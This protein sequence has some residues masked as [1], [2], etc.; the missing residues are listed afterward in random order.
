MKQAHK[1]MP[2]P[3]EIFTKTKL[4]QYGFGKD[5]EELCGPASV[6]MLLDMGGDPSSI[7]DVVK[8]MEQH[9][10]FVQGIGTILA[11]VAR[12]FSGSLTYMPLLP[13]WLLVAM[14]KR[15][16]GFAHSIKQSSGS[17]GHIVC[18]SGYRDGLIYFYDPN[19]NTDAPR[20]VSIGEW[21][22]LSNRRAVAMRT[23]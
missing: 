12:C 3:R 8:A 21:R 15:G 1:M 16:F 2:I 23:A 20:K 10:A 18:V 13:V 11:K 19:Q 4:K 14:L 9:G 17:A 6:A 5:A 22:K 7:R